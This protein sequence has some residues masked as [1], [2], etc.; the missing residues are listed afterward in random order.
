[1]PFVENDISEENRKLFLQ[2]SVINNSASLVFFFYLL[3][4]LTNIKKNPEPKGSSTDIALL[5]F[6]KNCSLNIENSRKTVEIITQYPFSS[7]RKRIGTVIKHQE[8]GRRLL[9]HGSSEILL[10]CSSQMLSLKS[11]TIV[12]LNEEKKNI[13]LEAIKCC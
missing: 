6:A 9:E 11:N 3:I 10:A 5:C 12:Q 1:M 2:L 4:F 7:T 8:I 13:I